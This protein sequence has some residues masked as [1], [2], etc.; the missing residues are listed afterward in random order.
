MAKGLDYNNH[1]HNRRGFWLPFQTG[2]HW[3][4]LSSYLDS[5]VG[6]TNLLSRFEKNE[7]TH[8][9][10]ATIGVEFATKTVALEQARVKIQIWDTAGQERY[11]AITH[12]YYKGA[13]G[14]LL[15]FDLSRRSTYENVSKWI[16]ELKDNAQEGMVCILIGTLNNSQVWGGL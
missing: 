6:K 9:S 7:F 12:A 13:S 3:R 10:K 5:G 4:F 8:E 11:R 1:E 16:R 14:A 2:R 15:V